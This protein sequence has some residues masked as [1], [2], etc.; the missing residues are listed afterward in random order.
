MEIRLLVEEV[1]LSAKSLLARREI[2]E[3]F[4]LE[5]RSKGLVV[6]LELGGED[7]DGIPALGKGQACVSKEHQH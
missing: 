1:E 2:G 3:R 4:G 5:P 7:V 6:Q